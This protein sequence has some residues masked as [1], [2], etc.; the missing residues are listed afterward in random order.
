MNLIKEE[1]LNDLIEVGLVI[2]AFKV[3]C[4]TS[5]TICICRDLLTRPPLGRLFTGG[6]VG[7]SLEK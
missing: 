4:R 5:S 7:L 6:N 1:F 3:E 2:R